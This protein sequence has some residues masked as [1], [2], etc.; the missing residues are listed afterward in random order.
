MPPSCCKIL[1]LLSSLLLL[2]FEWEGR[3]E[4]LERE[5]EAT[6]PARRREV[7]RLLASYPAP[8]VREALLQALGDPDAGVRTE[9]AEAAGRVRLK[10]AVP[11]LLDWLGDA[12]AGVRTSAARALGEIGAPRAVAP[13]TR[14]LGDRQSDVRKAG[15]AAL[16]SIGTPEV[17]VPLLGRLDDSDTS[18][19]KAA[20]EA[21]G[22][23]GD[24]QAIVPLMG[25]LRDDSPE[26]RQTI[27]AALGNLGNPRATAGLLQGL[28]DPDA[29]ARL[30]AIGA[31]GRLGASEA[32]PSLVP[33]VDEADHRVARAAVAALGAIGGERADDAVIASLARRETRATAASVLVDRARRARS[34]P[35]DGAT[36]AGVARLAQALEGARTDAH[37]TAVAE[38][39]ERLAA[40]ASIEAATDALL[41][42]LES[43]RGAKGPVMGA[44]GA[45]GSPR[46]LVPLLEQLPADDAEVQRAAVA[47]LE[48]LLPRI[49]PDGRAADPLL[50]AL[51]RVPEAL[52]PRVVRL[53]GAVGAERAV[54]KLRELLDNRQA[55]LRLA[56]VEALGAIGDPGAATALVP[57]LADDDA[58]TRFE[59]GRA[60][61]HAAT[62]RTVD[63]LLGLLI[64]DAPRDRHAVLLAVGGALGRLQEAGEVP[65]DLARRARAR[66]RPIVLASRDRALATRGIDALGRWGAADN[67]PL[68]ERV[69]EA[70]PPPLRRQA[71]GALG[72][73]EGERARLLLRRGLER[74]GDL[75]LKAVAA[76]ALGQ[77]GTAEDVP[78]LLKA[79]RRGSWPLPAAA[80]F[81]LARLVRRGEAGDGLDVEGLCR[82]ARASRDPYVRANLAVILAARDGAVCPEGPDPARW[83]EGGHAPAVRGAA[84]RWLAAQTGAG[85][86]PA[87]RTARPLEACAEGD[88]SPAVAQACAEPG[89]P[90]LGAEVDAYAHGPDGTE[91][92]A[93]RWVALRLADGTVWVARTDLN[94]HLRLPDAPDGALVLEDPL[95]A[96]LER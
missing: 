93:D 3:L 48:A 81:G 60:L 2:G 20:A 51:G 39:L 42:A 72:G 67:A 64:D 74:S 14:L 36:P 55:E 19:R 95:S 5:L 94:G 8:A 32:V 33:L 45:T 40:F 15:V 50:A 41:H 37:A 63:T 65:P 61:G 90:P 84:A 69:L 22:E 66:L 12:D 11:R 54:P 26:V 46:V 24:P 47:G 71:M 9:A 83:L 89:L 30:I 87:D 38:V 82:D 79:L 23:L 25:Q 78:V 6:D 68:L 27:L 49:Q 17:V 77:R 62:P 21:L 73:L 59:A 18:V 53:L 91:R 80:A 31:L 56:A 13:L 70:G 4:R 75:S 16:A 34:D 44:L 28:A 88:P 29:E 35:D 43:G 7:V 52:R 76:A 58:Q 57:L 1:L 10:E 96:P 92:M 85:S 86:R